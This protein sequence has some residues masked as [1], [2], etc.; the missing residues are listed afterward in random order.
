MRTRIGHHA[1]RI[2]ETFVNNINLP[3]ENLSDEIENKTDKFWSLKVGRVPPT[4][5]T[6]KLQNFFY[7]LDYFFNVKDFKIDL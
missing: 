2:H 4:Q 1:A 6:F 3:N 5:I 7:L